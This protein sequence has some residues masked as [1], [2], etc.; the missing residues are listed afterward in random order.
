MLRTLS[1]CLLIAGAGCSNKTESPPAPPA[2]T[3]AVPGA[4]AAKPSKNPAEAKKL[5]AAGAVVIDVRPSPE[6]SQDHLPNAVNI[7]VAELPTRLAEVDKL[8]GSDKTKPIV[9]Y[10]MAGGMAS[11]AKRELAAAGY[12]NVENGGGIDDLR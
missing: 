8:V 3:P 5:I 9:V 11:K 10:C 4:G 12:S 7:P 2:N 1:L 6:F